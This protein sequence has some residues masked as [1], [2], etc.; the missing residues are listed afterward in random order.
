MGIRWGNIL[1]I[2]GR[3]LN[4]PNEDPKFFKFLKLV[5]DFTTA[6]PG[7]IQFQYNDEIGTHVGGFDQLVS[8]SRCAVLGLCQDHAS[9]NNGKIT[10]FNSQEAELVKKI[11][12]RFKQRDQ[13]SCLRATGKFSLNNDKK[14]NFDVYNNDT[15]LQE[16][17]FVLFRFNSNNNNNNDDD[18]ENNTRALFVMNVNEDEEIELVISKNI[19]NESVFTLKRGCTRNTKWFSGKKYCR[20]Q[21]T[22][23]IKPLESEFYFYK[24]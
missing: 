10:G 4:P 22:I 21:H 7:A 12:D 1:M 11:N 23:C 24:R 18:D 5:F 13:Y 8:G 9:R 19:Y 15:W 20:R 16:N 17:S 3:V 6:Y 14:F 2:G